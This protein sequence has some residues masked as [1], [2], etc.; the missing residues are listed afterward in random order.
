MFYLMIMLMLRY[1]QTN[2]QLQEICWGDCNWTYEH[3]PKWMQQG[4]LNWNKGSIEL[5]NGSRIV[6]ASTSSSVVRGSTF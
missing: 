2:L 6:A 4:V 3:L 5:E 1:W